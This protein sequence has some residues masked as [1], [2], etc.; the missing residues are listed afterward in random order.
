MR[1][2]IIYCATNLIN[3]KQYVGQTIRKLQDRIKQHYLNSKN[4]TNNKFARALRK[5]GKQDWKWEVLVE[6][7][8]QDQLNLLEKSYIWGLSTFEFGYNS[9]TGGD[10][11][12]ILF[13]EETRNKMSMSK[14]GI[15][16]GSMPQETRRKI[17]IAHTGKQASEDTKR[18][19]SIVRIGKL[20][21]KQTKQRMSKVQKGRVVSE[22][23]REKLSV[24][25]TGKS[26]P[27]EVK[28]KIS[29]SLIGNKRRLGIP[30]NE[31]SKQ[32]IS[33][34]GVGRHQTEE[35]KT[36]MSIGRSKISYKITKPN[37]EEEIIKNLNKYCKDNNLS[38]GSMYAIANGR[39]AQHK[40]YRVEK[41]EKKGDKK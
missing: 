24:I 5:Y 27:E 26:L 9:T 16:H 15:L 25:N 3:G 36:N 18:K 37:G 22:T 13:C 41:L 17:S 20:K 29:I 19:M 23:T 30:H 40:E 12:N 8:S 1:T 7:I 10:C 38:C 39:L 11:G 6:N 31:Q 32:K 35:A 33:A 4:N 28:R 34:S 21:S 14:L 2:G